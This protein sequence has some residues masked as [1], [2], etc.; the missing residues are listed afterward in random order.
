[1]AEILAG[2]TGA[3]G[4]DEMLV[5]ACHTAAHALSARMNDPAQ[6]TFILRREERLE[7]LV[8]R[9]I[10]RNR[11]PGQFPEERGKIRELAGLGET[12][13]INLGEISVHE[14]IINLNRHNFKGDV[15]K[16]KEN[17]ES[18]GVAC[19]SLG[20]Y[21]SYWRCA[22]RNAITLGIAWLLRGF[23]R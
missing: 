14:D 23:D 17:V 6:G 10:E 15:N 1:M 7:M 11:Y 20:R 22:L 9:V 19:Y 16:I 13:K 18:A 8:Q 2:L 12:L 4:F 3:C 21:F 5:V